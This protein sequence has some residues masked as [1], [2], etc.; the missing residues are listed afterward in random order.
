MYG[1]EK[2]Y[3]DHD[4]ALRAQGKLGDALVA[5]QAIAKR[6]SQ[7]KALEKNGGKP[8]LRGRAPKDARVEAVRKLFGM[9]Y[10][11]WRGWMDS[12]TAD[13]KVS[14]SAKVA[15]LT[16]LLEAGVTLNVEECE[17]FGDFEQGELELRA[18]GVTD[19]LVVSE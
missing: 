2:A 19:A 7:L 10:E 5:N 18:D 9:S 3:K 13:E 14:A 17:I 6:T 1:S 15:A 12:Q 16:A 4:A 8:G 11:D